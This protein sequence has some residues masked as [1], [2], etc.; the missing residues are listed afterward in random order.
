MTLEE[1]ICEAKAKQRVW[2]QEIERMRKQKFATICVH[3]AYT[4]EEAIR[5]NQGAV[6]EPVYS[7]T[8]QMHPNADCLEAALSYQ[9]PAWAYSRIANPTVGYLEQTIA[10]LEGYG[11]QFKTSAVCASSGMAAIKA[12]TEPFLTDEKPGKKNIVSQMQVYGGTFQLFAE[13]YAK[14]RNVEVRWVENIG[15]LNE[16][17]SKIDGNT[18]F[19]F[20]EIPS[21]PGLCLFDIEKVAGLAHSQETALITDSTLATPA[22]CRPLEFGSD[23]VVHSLTKTMMWAGRAIGGAIVS[24][25]NIVSKVLNEE[26]KRD[27]AGWVKL[28]PMRDSGSCFTADSAVKAMD[29]IR[30]LRGTMDSLSKSSLEVA[31]FLEKH[32]KVERANYPG[33]KTFSQRDLAKKYLKLVDSNENR[34]GHLLSFEVKGG[35]EAARRTL[36]KLKLIFRVTDLGKIKSLAVIPTISTHQQQGEE[37]RQK[38]SIPSNLIRLCVGGEDPNDLI[39]DLDAALSSA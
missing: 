22:L 16:W 5:S 37:A 18:R 12:A 35:H 33:L 30:V 36:N 24:R 27:Y 1:V 13:R 29:C 9:I 34:Y 14:E 23:V 28:W 32:D 21:N 26:A 3:G 4:A 38:A 7:S 19:V 31:E 11:S 8:S 39:A 10:M 2:E 17:E 20:G 25:E 15:D 6:M